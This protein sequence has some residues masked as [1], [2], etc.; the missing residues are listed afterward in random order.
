MLQEMG[1]EAA[2]AG[3]SMNGESSSF[4]DYRTVVASLMDRLTEGVHC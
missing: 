2:M 3:L 1:A 4:G